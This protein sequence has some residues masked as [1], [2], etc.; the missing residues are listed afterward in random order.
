MTV[1]EVPD[2]PPRHDIP[3]GGHSAFTLVRADAA[4]PGMAQRG[5]D[6]HDERQVHYLWWGPRDAPPVVCLHGGV[7]TA[8]MY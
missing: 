5:S 1:A 3:T 4:E 6:V 2:G 7:Q 8:Y